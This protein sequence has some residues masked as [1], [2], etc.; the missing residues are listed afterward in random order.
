MTEPW[1]AY[2][3]CVHISVINLAGKKR[4][5]AEVRECFILSIYL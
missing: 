4:G 3:L 2:D 1:L 5:A